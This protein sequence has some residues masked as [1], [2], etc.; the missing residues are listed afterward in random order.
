MVGAA[1]GGGLFSKIVF[2][3]VHGLKV[4]VTCIILVVPMHQFVTQNGGRNRLWRILLI[5]ILGKNHG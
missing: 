5:L 3:I 4:S 2:V 1:G